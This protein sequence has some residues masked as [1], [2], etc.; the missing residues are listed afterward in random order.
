M[1]INLMNVRHAVKYVFCPLNIFR[2]YGTSR[3]EGRCNGY[4]TDGDYQTWDEDPSFEQRCKGCS[5]FYMRT[6]I[7]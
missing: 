6:R 3:T 5:T 7:K 1:K 4:S 2:G